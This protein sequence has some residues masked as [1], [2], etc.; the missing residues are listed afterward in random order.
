[1]AAA[2]AATAGGGGA[3]AEAAAEAR[4]ATRLEPLVFFFSFS[5]IQTT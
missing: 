3:A 5:L 1:M 2:T 4:E